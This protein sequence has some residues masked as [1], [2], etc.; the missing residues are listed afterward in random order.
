MNGVYIKVQRGYFFV[1]HWKKGDP[2]E[3]LKVSEL[4][5]LRKD[6]RTLAFAAKSLNL[7]LIRGAES[8]RDIFL[9]SRRR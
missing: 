6:E 9:R 4:T 8:F 5:C 7:P 2:G 3:Y 1:K